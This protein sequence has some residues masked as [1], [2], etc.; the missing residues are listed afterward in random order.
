MRILVGELARAFVV[1]RRGLRRV[2]KM[3]ELGYG[4]GHK[5]SG[6]KLRAIRAVNGV[7]RPPRRAA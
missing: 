5:Y 1:A 7:G 2:G 6:A 3:A 4:Y